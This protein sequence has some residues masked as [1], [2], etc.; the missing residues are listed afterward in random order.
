MPTRSRE[1][2][3]GTNAT[4]ARVPLYTLE[5][6]N[7]KMLVQ[8]DGFKILRDHLEQTYSYE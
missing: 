3:K 6:E 7:V 1:I 8:S 2:A 5:K 4:R